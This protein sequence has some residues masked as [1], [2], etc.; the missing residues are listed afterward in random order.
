MPA[1]AGF[2]VRRV[3]RSFRAR[4]PGERQPG[5]PLPARPCPQRTTRAP[6]LVRPAAR[7]P[8]W[9]S[10]LR[11]F[12]EGLLLAFTGLIA[13]MAVMGRAAGWFG[14]T[15]LTDSLLP[16]T[17]TVLLLAIAGSLFLWA[18]S[19]LRSRWLRAGPW[20]PAFAALLVA[21]GGVLF[22]WR[23]DFQADLRSLRTL[24]GGVEQAGRAAVAHQVY[25][26]YRRA[27]LAAMQ[28]I[29]RR[30]PPY[31]QPMR[32]AA[33]RNRIDVGVLVGIGVAESSFVPRDSR[34]GGR[35][36]F[37]ITAPPQAAAARVR[38]LLGV[39]TLDYRNPR[40]N[41]WLAAATLRHYLD[42]MR[43]DLFLALLAYNIGPRNGGLLSIMR[44]YGARDF[45]TIQPYL[46]HLP[47]DYPIRV[48]TAA[49]AYRLWDRL[50]ALPRYEDGDN[51]RVIQSLGIPGLED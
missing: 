49:L 16:F 13:T 1:F 33:R 45:F 6:P 27:D 40:Q 12:L 29:L 21:L 41:A 9:Q 39:D 26:A 19:R 31:G 38:R 3:K 10:G 46:Q 28:T 43:G 25:A 18:W 32:E 4:R 35:G 11:L 47:R 30:T 8:V 14:G 7:A 36:L 42:E 51:A 34:D 5:K 23:A 48:L 44:Q 15:G 20:R 17:G 50:G 2:W 24:V 37:Q 22:A